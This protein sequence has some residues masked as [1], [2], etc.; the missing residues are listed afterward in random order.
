M[1]SDDQTAK[2]EARVMLARRVGQARF[3]EQKRIGDRIEQMLYETKSEEVAEVLV[4]LARHVFDG[5]KA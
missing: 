5:G 3:D 2:F 1:I 4:G